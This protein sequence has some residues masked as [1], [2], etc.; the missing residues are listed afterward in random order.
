MET[1]M[2]DIKKRLVSRKFWIAVFGA[3][4]FALQGDTENTLL[5]VVAYLGAQGVA[6]AAENLTVSP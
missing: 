3:A 6:D 2:E 5:V 4:Y 1:V